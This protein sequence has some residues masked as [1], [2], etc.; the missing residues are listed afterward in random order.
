MVVPSVPIRQAE[1]AKER[2]I[3]GWQAAL[4]VAVKLD[5]DFGTVGE[6]VTVVFVHFVQN[7]GVPAKAP[8]VT[9]QVRNLSIR[10]DL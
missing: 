4:V 6:T 7:A 9:L 3:G 2:V 10:R 1:S 5:F 8:F